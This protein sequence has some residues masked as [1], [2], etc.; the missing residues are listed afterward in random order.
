MQIE[1]NGTR[2][3]VDVHG[4]QYEP[5]GETMREKPVTFVLHGGPGMDHSYYLPWL[6]PLEKH[7]QMIFI[8][9][10]G[11]GRSARDS[12]RET[13]TIETFADD[14]EELRK[15]LGLERISLMGNSFGGM[16]GLVYATRYPHNLDRLVL[17]DTAPSWGTWTE[18][19][20]IALKKGSKEQRKV[21][22]RVFDGEVRTDEEF[23]AWWDV[24]ISLYFHAYDDE[25][26]RNMVGRT[27][28]SPLVAARMFREI[29][30]NYDVRKDLWMIRCPTLVLVGKHDWI[31]PVS[32]SEEIARLIPGSRLVV[33]DKSGHMPFIEETQ[34][35]L[36]VVGDFLGR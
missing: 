13:W 14:I 23:K 33:F 22:T 35:F 16:W 31:T 30:P 18:A 36:D 24:M 34:K 19:Q 17:I 28:G 1:V 11:T 15:K 5:E 26:G 9:H 12:S 20:Q 21:F 6:K 29:I 7:T 32:Q 10:R 3:F 25:A 2:L 4:L 27:K 8:D